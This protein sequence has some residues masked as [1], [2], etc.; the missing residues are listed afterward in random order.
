M[1]IT[2]SEMNS[3]VESGVRII[4]GPTSPIHDIVKTC[5]RIASTDATVLLTGETG[6]GKEVFA[7]LV[8]EESPRASRPLVPVNCG[9]IPEALLESELFGHVRG[10]FTGATQNRR[11]RIAAADGGTLFLDEIGEMPLSLQ[12]KLLR[13]LQE[14]RYE[15]VGSTEA[16][17]ADFRLIAATNKDL[18]AEVA[19][20]R[21]RRDLYYRLL[22]C[23]VEVPPLRQRLGDVPRLFSAFWASRGE[24]RLVEPQVIEALDSYDWPGNVRELENL[25]ERLSVCSDGTVIR[26]R[27]L[28]PYVRGRE[29]QR[30]PAVAL[31]AATLSALTPIPADLPASTPAPLAS[32]PA[33]ADACGRPLEDDAAAPLRLLEG[34]APIR[35]DGSLAEGRSVDLPRLLRTLEDSYIDAAL[36]RTGGNR[37]AAADLLGLQRTTLVEKLRRR[38]REASMA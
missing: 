29:P 23:P 16:I 21:F 19:A 6:T 31:A 5:K 10:A 30:P 8:H 25:V 18:A 26:L 36:A 12:V 27:D 9:A 1:M 3:S 32:A 34:G 33:P 15:P 38:N 13:V 20:G 22:V 24:T 35:L 7:R 11:G 14:R 28:P 2:A 17:P 4:C 37:K